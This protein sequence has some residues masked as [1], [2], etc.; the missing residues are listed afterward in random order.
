MLLH[1]RDDRIDVLLRLYAKVLFNYLDIY[2]Q[3][4]HVK[5]NT[6]QIFFINKTQPHFLR[7]ICVAWP[8]MHPLE[9]LFT[10]YDQKVVGSIT[11]ET[12]NI[13]LG[14]AN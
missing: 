9:N 11:N 1:L 4:F 3:A 7:Q 13:S 6:F 8:G 10:V 14:F 5:V 2:S 12:A